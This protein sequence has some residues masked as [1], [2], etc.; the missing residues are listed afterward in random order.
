[1]KWWPVVLLVMLLAL[2]AVVP[3][4]RHVPQYY[5]RLTAADSLLR[6]NP[7]SALA[8]VDALAADSLTT[9]A[10]LAYHALLLTQACYKCYKDITTGDDSDI[11][12][13]LAYYKKHP[14]EREKLTRAYIYKGAVMEELGHPDSAMLYY[15][16]AE[17]TAAP[18]DYFNLGYVKMRIANLYQDQKSQDSTAIIYLKQAIYYFENTRDTNYLISCYGDLGK[19]CGIRYPDSTEYY[20]KHAI[21]LAQQFNSTK[22][23]TYKSTLAGFYFYYYKDYPQAKDLAV[24]VMSNG[25]EHCKER[26]FYYYAA[27]SYV[28]MGMVDSSKLVLNATPAPV[29]AVDS[30]NRYQVIA[31]IAESENDMVSYGLNMSQSKEAKIQI[32]TNSKESKL[33]T[34]ESEFDR[35]QV[36]RQESVAA[37]HNFRL[38]IALSVA[39]ILLLLLF[40]LI[41]R[42]KRRLYR[43]RQERIEVEKVL[44]AQITEL[45]ERQQYLEQIQGGVSELV[46]F[47]ID[48]LN[49][50]FES[51][52]FKSKIDNNRARSII[53]LSSVIIDLN[54]AYRIIHIK[55]SDRF[56]ERMKRSV[57][58]EYKGIVSFIEKNYPDLTTKDIRLFCLL[59]AN[60]PAQIIKMCM[61][62]TNVKSVSNNR[63]FFI[64]KK[65]GLDMTLNEF[66]DHY[67]KNT[68]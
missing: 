60:V 49:E 14:A 33:K 36:E 22:Q 2:G 55:L 56:W 61:N 10:D 4:C 38:T 17:A 20:L 11:N 31:E 18:D 7:D 5:S 68:L 47:R 65:L 21:N 67:M 25:S 12:R 63:S 48:A 52:R 15:K 53:S 54:D 44:N 66:I 28:R 32:I 58:G 39:I 42:L 16:T 1:M 51:I 40:G 27:L 35:K 8:I 3:G 46:K 29:D 30:M 37:N 57:D 26:Q 34:V 13:A 62:Y 43:N 6:T 64:K 45:N 50:L 19:L 24:D 23:Y 59:C 41:L 9:E